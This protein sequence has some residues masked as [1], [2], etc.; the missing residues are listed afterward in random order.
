MNWL[1]TSRGSQDTNLVKATEARC[2]YCDI[3]QGNHQHTKKNDRCGHQRRESIDTPSCWRKRLSHLPLKNEQN[4]EIETTTVDSTIPKQGRHR[5]G[6]DLDPKDSSGLGRGRRAGGMLLAGVEVWKREWWRRWRLLQFSTGSSSKK[7]LSE[8]LSLAVRRRT[9]KSHLGGSSTRP[10]S[11]LGLLTLAKSP[12]TIKD[13]RTWQGSSLSVMGMNYKVK[14]VPRSW[15][16]SLDSIRFGPGTSNGMTFQ[17]QGKLA[18][19][20]DGTERRN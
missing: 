14:A 8:S 2:E 3:I 16:C 18:L 9:R 17:A 11:P 10:V 6:F 19:W 4:L 1:W 13:L 12:R 15:G 20:K 7:K 5:L